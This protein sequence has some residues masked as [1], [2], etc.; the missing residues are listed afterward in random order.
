M[1]TID[2][3]PF[4][5]YG[6]LISGHEGQAD[7]LDMKTQFFTIYGKEGY[8]ISKRVGNTLT[9][10]GF[11]IA[12]GLIDFQS[13]I[14]A[15]QTIFKAS[16][17]RSVVLDQDAISCFCTNG[18]EIDRVHIYPNEAFARFKINLLIV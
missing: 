10:N 3:I 12:N 15:L 5:D 14:T 2:T 17:L 8:Q 18:F 6:L 11:I 13:K 7:L 4:T 16:G 9:I 1:Y